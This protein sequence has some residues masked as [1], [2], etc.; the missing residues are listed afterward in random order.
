MA[1]F[2]L[3]FNR[4]L[5][6]IIY[7]ARTMILKKIKSFVF[8]IVF[9]F[10]TVS[11]LR[12]ADE[13]FENFSRAIFNFNMAFDDIVMEPVAK[14]YNK[15]PN[16]IK[17]GAVILPQTLQHYQFQIIFYKEILNSLVILLRV[18]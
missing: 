10:L 13:C 3:N 8:I 5:G 15:L 6:K 12:A 9:T 4:I 14:G 7:I 17:T 1:I 11:N 16:P 2:K 18:L